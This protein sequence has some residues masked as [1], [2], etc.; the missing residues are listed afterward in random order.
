MH[1]RSYDF[2]YISSIKFVY[3]LT[4]RI[5]VFSSSPTRRPWC[6][7]SPLLRV[8]IDPHPLTTELSPISYPEGVPKACRIVSSSVPERSSEHVL[9]CSFN[10]SRFSFRGKTRKTEVTKTV[11]TLV[12]GGKLT[13]L[14]Q[15]LPAISF[16]HII[17]IK[18]YFLS[19]MQSSML[20]LLS[21]N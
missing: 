17:I 15:L 19:G 12:N 1:S 5:S 3:P 20:V 10:K 4:T 18:L 7:N 6:S 21:S 16:T 2:L 13:E 9:S 8:Q 14:W 11:E